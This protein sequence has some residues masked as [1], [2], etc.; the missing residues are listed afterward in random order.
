MLFGLVK[1]QTIIAVFNVLLGAI[2]IRGVFCLEPQAIQ[3]ILKADC[4]L[5]RSKR[6]VLR[7]YYYRD[8]CHFW[9]YAHR[10]CFGGWQGNGFIS[11]IRSV[12]YLR[13]LTRRNDYW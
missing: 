10:V 7:E 11:A 2:F 13:R 8:R 3:P 12:N 5:E 9:L 1:I 4:A 6:G